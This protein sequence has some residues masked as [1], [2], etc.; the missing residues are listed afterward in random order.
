MTEWI[1]NPN[2]YHHSL[3]GWLSLCVAILIFL[4]GFISIV[5]SNYSR[6]GYVLCLL[7]ITIWFWL[8]CFSFAYFANNEK[9]A[10]S[11]FSTAYFFLP[12][13][14]PVAY[15]FLCSFLDIVHKR[16]VLSVLF[17]GLS[18]FFSVAQLI[19][20]GVFNSVYEYSWGFYTHYSLS[21]ICIAFV[22]YFFAIML[23]GLVELYLCY[24][25]TPTSSK[26]KHKRIKILAVSYSTGYMA[27]I[28]FQP[29]FG[30]DFM[31]FGFIFIA[32][33]V[34]LIFLAIEYFHLLGINAFVANKIVQTMN[35]ALV[36]CDSDGLI[37]VTNHAFTKLT[38]YK[39]PEIIDK[40]ISKFIV[41]SKPNQSSIGILPLLS[42]SKNFMSIEA[43]V[44]TKSHHLIP[45]SLSCQ[46][47][48]TKEDRI[49][50]W[51]VIA[52]NISEYKQ[53]IEKLIYLSNHD[54]L[55]GI[56]NR[57]RFEEDLAYHI[58]YAKRN[59]IKSALFLFDIDHF[60]EI[61]DS[62]GHQF[63]DKLLID[64]AVL[65]KNNLREVD[66][67]GRI[68]GD[69]FAAI[70]TNV[71]ISDLDTI[72]NN[73]LRL[74]RNNTFC[75]NDQTISVSSSIGI[76]VIPDDGNDYETL[77]TNADLSL[78]HC[79]LKNRNS[80][81]IYKTENNWNNAFKNK[82]LVA[83]IVKSAI[84]NNELILY[85][86]PICNLR[87]NR[88]THYELLLRIKNNNGIIQPNNFLSTAEHYGL[89][90]DINMFVIQQTMKYIAQYPHIRFSCNISANALNDSRL[91]TLLTDNITNNTF[92]PEQMIIEITENTV[93]THIDSATNF[94]NH[95][96]SLGVNF[97]LDDFGVGLSSFT[98]LKHL[99]VDYL[100]LDGSFIENI[101]D[102]KIDEQFV[103]SM[104]AIS[105]ALKIKTVAEFVSNS[106]SEQ[107]LRK[108][109]IDFT[110][111]YYYGKPDKIT[112][113]HSFKAI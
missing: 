97:A 78:Y 24:K 94:I 29:A 28:D 54:Y 19:F 1:L 37:H 13:I 111:G 55:T 96:K 49:N 52:H 90:N 11:W 64:F 14:P 73:I 33:F 82:L 84:Q 57:K 39:S 88:F 2:Y 35:D 60:K 25:S 58:K 93:A 87:K 53:N 38:H 50:G 20:H 62:F 8:T 106:D 112:N 108:I 102:N 89:M 22:I 40:I 23:Y 99:P 110:Q 48:G 26:N 21:P 46:R 80:Y 5:R 68:G 83:N 76:T 31:P 85:A 72:A 104:I 7:N 18:G 6:N 41:L 98:H 42:R 12:L 9:T 10:F 44:K 86:Q 67:L 43:S 70:I 100:K 92:N 61:N 105:Q 4:L 15:L 74:I 91:L 56:F 95:C 66:V 34:T 103:V 30:V 101:C 45:V 51:I 69:E 32:L 113:W 107:L 63:G 75:I 71:T 77:I 16:L 17:F 27:S 3:L 65:I 59:S 109:G 36:V 47:L 81:M 79:K